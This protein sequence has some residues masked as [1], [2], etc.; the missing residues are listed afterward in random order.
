MH[1]RHTPEREELAREL[2][3]YF[4]R[5]MTPERR[6]ALRNVDGD[7]PPPG[8]AVSQAGVTGSGGGKAYV[9]GSSFRPDTA[10][11]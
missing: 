2:R 10:I 4:A 7:V 1:L 3:A 11:L 8:A 9:T 6:E 5:L